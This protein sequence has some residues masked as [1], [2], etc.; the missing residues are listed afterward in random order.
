MSATDET[1]RTFVG[2][3][4][5]GAAREGVLKA[6]ERFRAGVRDRRAVR[7]ERASNL[8]MTLQFLGDTPQEKLAPIDEALRRAAHGHAP[9][10]L[11]LSHPAVFGGNR[12]R[13]VVIET[14]QGRDALIALQA[15]VSEALAELGFEPDRR[16]YTPHITIGRVRRGRK[17]HRSEIDGLL[18]E[19]GDITTGATMEIAEVVHFK[20]VLSP[21]GA[22][23]SRLETVPLV[24]ETT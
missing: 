18:P 10:T 12:P 15:E 6:Q 11:G 24:D 17:I 13:V 16:P 8:H 19:V 9:F 21:E 2:I 14:A 7:W 20:S 3:P 1:I 22:T 23:Y 5:T 4:L